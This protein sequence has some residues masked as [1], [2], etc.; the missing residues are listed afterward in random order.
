MERAGGRRPRVA[1]ARGRAG[2]GVARRPPDRALRELLAL[3][4]SDWAFLV[5]RG[6]AGAYPRERFDAHA[7]AFDAAIVEPREPALRNLAPHLA[8]WTIALP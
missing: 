8:H 7:A 5:T 2:R 4:A 1:P 3:Q 6:T